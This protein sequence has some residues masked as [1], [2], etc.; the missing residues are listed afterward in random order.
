MLNLDDAHAVQLDELR[1]H[2]H[3]APDDAL[4]LIIRLAHARHKQKPDVLAPEFKPHAKRAEW[5]VDEDHMPG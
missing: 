1:Q 2:F 4:R 5:L 3:L